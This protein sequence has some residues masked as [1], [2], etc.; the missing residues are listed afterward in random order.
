MCGAMERPDI[1]FLNLPE[2]IKK[3]LYARNINTIE[4]LSTNYLED[5][6]VEVGNP[7]REVDAGQDQLF[8]YHLRDLGVPND[9]GEEGRAD[10]SK[11]PLRGYHHA[12]SDQENYCHG[13]RHVEADDGGGVASGT[14][15]GVPDDSLSDSSSHSSSP[16]ASTS[17]SVST[18]G[19]GPSLAASPPGRRKYSVLKSVTPWVH[20]KGHNSSVGASLNFAKDS[21]QVCMPRSNPPEGLERD[22]LAYSNYMK[23]SL[24]EVSSVKTGSHSLDKLLGNGL[25]GSK[26][27]FFYGKKTKMNKVLSLNLLFDFLAGSSSTAVAVF[28]HFSHVNDVTVI[29]SIL[30]EKIKRG[31][32]KGLSLDDIPNRLFVLR[33]RSWS[34]LVSFL[35]SIRKGRNPQK[36]DQKNPQKADQKNLQKADQQNPREW[37]Q[38]NPFASHPPN[39][40]CIGIDNF[41]NMLKHLS[42]QNSNTCFYLVRE[43]KIIS[44]MF[45]IPILIFDYAKCQVGGPLGWGKTHCKEE[46]AQEGNHT[47]NDYKCRSSKTKRNANGCMGYGKTNRL[48]PPEEEHATNLL[49]DDVQ[50]W[51][52]RKNKRGKWKASGLPFGGNDQGSTESSLGT[53]DSESIH[54]EET[55]RQGTNDDKKNAFPTMHNRKNSSN[56]TS[57]PHFAYN[58]FDF[59]LEVEVLQKMRGGKNLVRFTLL[60]S[61]N[62]ISHLYVNCCVKNYSLTDVE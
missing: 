60:K 43:L 20:L 25:Q 17:M 59:V 57:V 61:Q 38:Q 18:T 47:G 13:G 28:I 2:R 51:S 32:K 29:D 26:L 7:L 24:I 55:T 39:V 4:K 15:G 49:T 10:C 40:A 45:S 50:N 11:D 19:K 58:L 56:K 42:V 23:A 37:D 31:R 53:D 1:E 48:N 46:E 44:V 8:S 34:E 21:G 16:S 54:I 6:D 41:T 35:G 62:S 9:G 30:K 22:L 33:V 14:V 3:K 52:G 12:V 36:G 27:Y 5:V